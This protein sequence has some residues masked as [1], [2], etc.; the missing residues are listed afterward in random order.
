MES[1]IPQDEAEYVSLHSADGAVKAEFYE[2]LQDMV[3]GTPTT[4]LFFIVGDWNARTGPYEEGTRHILGK[5]GLGQRCNNGE[6]LIFILR[7]ILEDRHQHQQKTIACF[8]DFKTAFYCIPKIMAMIKAYYRSTTLRGIVH[9][10]LS[11]ALAIRS[12][13]QQDCVL[14]PILFNHATNWDIG[15]ALQENYGVELAPGL[16]LT[17]LDYAEHIALL[18]S[19]FGFKSMAPLS[20]LHVLTSCGHAST[21]R[22]AC[23][24]SIS[25]SPIDYVI[26]PANDNQARV[27]RAFAYHA[28]ARNA[29]RVGERGREIGR[30]RHGGQLKTWLN[31]VK[32]DVERMGLVI[33]CGLRQWNK[34]CVDICEE[35]ASDRRQR[36]A[37]IR[38]IHEADP[39]NYR[40]KSDQIKNQLSKN[41]SLIRTLTPIRAYANYKKSTETK[42]II[43][44]FKSKDRSRNIYR[45][46]TI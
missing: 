11:E 17:D 3:A 18:A 36:A 43:L 28:N 14:S 7:H 46:S 37:A 26:I 5:H 6:R 22:G 13:V 31:T 44:V 35:L 24:K 23:K 8:I 10:N 25:Q 21:A 30:Y 27:K 2:N 1:K 15:K 4:D 16:R 39:F 34:H 32:P 45:E 42:G 38:D 29:I 9:N 40:K 33:V 19:S 41:I 12:S 20:H